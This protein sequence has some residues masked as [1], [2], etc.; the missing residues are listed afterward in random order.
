MQVPLAAV[1][2]RPATLPDAPAGCSEREYLR[3]VMTGLWRPRPAPLGVVGEGE[4]RKTKRWFGLTLH[5]ENPA[6]S[7]RVWPGG[8]TQMLYDYGE[9]RR[10][11]GDDGD[12]VDV[13]L[14]PKPAT[15]PQVHVVYQLAAPDFMVYDEVKCFV[16]FDS[17]LDA[18]LAYEAH[19]TNPAFFGG[20]DSFDTGSFVAHVKAHGTCPGDPP[21]TLWDMW[22]ALKPLLGDRDEQP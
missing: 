14:G 1:L 17:A 11:E 15:A 10:T 18:K 20:M 22:E 2:D 9:I 7:I 21:V 8:A 4:S 3:G 19:Y 5:I 12:P 13:Y 16:G 6:G